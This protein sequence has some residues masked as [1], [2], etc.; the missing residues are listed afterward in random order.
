MATTTNDDVRDLL[1]RL[2]RDGI[3]HLWVAYTDYNGR[4]QGKA[5]PRSRF[6]GTV[7]R[8]I[9]FARANLGHN[10]TD[11]AASDTAFGAQTGDFFAVPDP[12][13][14]APFPLYPATGRALA[15]MRREEGG[16]WDGCPR[17]MLARQVDAYAAAG[18]RVRA[19]FEPEAYLF[20]PEPAGGAS[21]LEPA[22]MYTVAALESQAALLHRLSETLEAMGVAVEQVAPEY[23]P[24]QV[25]INV[26][27]ADP[28]KAGDDLVTVKEVFRALARQAGLVASFM[29]KPFAELAGSGLHVHLSLRDRD[30]GRD[31]M[32]GDAGENDHPSGLSAAGRAMV[33]GLL[34]HA[35]ALVGVGA[36]TVNSY[37]RLQPGSWAPAHAAYGVGNRAGFIRVP[38]GARRRI[39]VRAGDNTANP[40][41]Y[42]AALLAAGLDGIRA[43][44]DPGPPTTENLGLLRADEARA[45]GIALLPRSAPAALA[46]A[47]ADPTIAAALGPTIFPEWLR[48]KRSEI[49]AYD[50]AVSPWERAAYLAT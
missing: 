8:G 33:G 3:D 27:H 40:Y 19:A 17:T 4:S 13:T 5:V 44:L 22:G 43:G 21:P 47:E 16:P 45:R 31:V 23:G 48:V 38:G 10:V 37:K 42:L 2:E 25:E 6:P 34:R 28:L 41:L 30:D 18:F 46:E 50:L 9:T 1:A 35:P 20:R 14:Y 11:H 7:S 36:P 15:W 49:A 29:P 32:A 12:T 24:G 26:G 39:E